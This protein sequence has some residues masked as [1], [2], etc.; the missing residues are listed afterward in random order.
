MRYCIWIPLCVRYARL[1]SLISGSK[2]IG[3]SGSFEIFSSPPQSHSGAL[4]SGVL[5]GKP[6]VMIRQ[7][8]LGEPLFV[9]PAKAESRTARPG[10]LHW[11]PAFAGITYGRQLWPKKT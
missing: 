8:L 1:Y 3:P 10:W 11:M 9:I 6:P 5:I 4:G 7:I 2:T